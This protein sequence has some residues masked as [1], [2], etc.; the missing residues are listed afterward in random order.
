MYKRQIHPYYLEIVTPEVDATCESLAK[1]HGVEFS[2]PQP[3]LGGGRTT[4]IVGGG[5]ISVRAPL[6]D[7][8]NTV[9]RPYLLVDD[10]EAAVENAVAAGATVAMGPTPLEGR[11]TF[12][13]YFL[14]GIEHG[15]W[16][17]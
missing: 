4:A 9:V 11:G 13:I 8:E 6:H 10:I 1:T 5:M 2:D 17:N 16:Q 12:A 7:A 3:E 15:L 14:G